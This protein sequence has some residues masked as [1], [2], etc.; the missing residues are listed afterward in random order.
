L[1]ADPLTGA[2]CAI[3]AGPEDAQPLPQGDQ[4]VVYAHCAAAES[5]DTQSLLEAAQMLVSCHQLAGAHCAP[6]A[7][8]LAKSNIV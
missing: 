1:E 4:E 3:A 2:H 5:D 6:A 7:S 8:E